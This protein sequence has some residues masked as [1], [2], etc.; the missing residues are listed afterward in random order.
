V[1]FQPDNLALSLPDDQTIPVYY[2]EAGR[3]IAA[4]FEP[5]QA[6][7]EDLRCLS[8][9]DVTDDAT[10]NSILPTAFGSSVGR[11]FGGSLNNQL[12]ARS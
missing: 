11:L 1:F 8:R 9:A 12:A 3:V 7:D 6:R 5:F 2:G 10:H 4:V